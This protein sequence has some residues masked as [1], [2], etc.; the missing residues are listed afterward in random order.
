MLEGVGTGAS[1]PNRASATTTFPCGVQLSNQHW[2]KDDNSKLT[3]EGRG[4]CDEKV[5]VTQAL[6]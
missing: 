2:S 4:R 5:D 3:G 6:A 1:Q